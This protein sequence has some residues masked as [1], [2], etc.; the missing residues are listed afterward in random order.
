LNKVFTLPGLKVAMLMIVATSIVVVLAVRHIKADVEKHTADTLKQ[1]LSVTQDS[2]ERWK[3]KLC[4]DIRP[5]SQSAEVLTLVQSLLQT[6]H[7][8]QALVN[9]PNQKRLRSLLGFYVNQHDYVGFFVISPDFISVSSMRDSNLGRI[10]LLRKRGEFLD[11]IFAGQ[12]LISLPQIS[13]VV[14]PDAYGR[15]VDG[16]PTMFVAAPV[17]NASGKVIAALAFRI[18][19]DGDYAHI[20]AMG[21]VGRSMETYV[22]DAHGRMLTSSRFDYQ[23]RKAGLLGP[24]QE[25]ALNIVLRDPGVNLIEEP[26]LLK[27]YMKRPLTYMAAAAVQ[28]KSGINLKG[29]NDY[30]GV[31]VV[32]AWQWNAREGYGLAV[33]MDVEDAYGQ[34]NV[35]RGMFFGVL[36]VLMFMFILMVFLIERLNMQAGRAMMV[37][38]ARYRQLF[39]LI[40]DA[41]AVH[42]QGKV[43]YCNAA[44]VK[45]FGAVGNDDLNGSSIL[46]LVH[47][48]DRAGVEERLRIAMHSDGIVPLN[49]ERLLRL[50]GEIFVAEVEGC[51]FKD[52]DGDA[53]LVVARDISRRKH[54]EEERERL[55][56]A[57]EQS[58]EGILITDAAGKILYANPVIA[59]MLGHSLEDLPG[60]LAA[61][62]C[63]GSQGDILYQKIATALNAGNIWQGDVTLHL[64]DGTQ[65][66]VE[67]RVSPVIQ[68]GETLY[69]VSMDRDI[70]D[71][72]RQQDK[73]GHAQRLESLGVLAGGIAHDFNNILATIMGNASLA[74]MKF[75]GQKDLGNYLCR[76]ED[77]SQRA[78]ALCKQMLAYS[79]KGH[80]I[81]RPVNISL[82]LQEIPKLLQVSISKKVELRLELAADIPTVQADITQLQQVMMNLVI[83]AS[84]A[85]GEDTGMVTLRTGVV[86]AEAYE[87]AQSCTGDD[88]E[89]GRYVLFEVQDSGCGMS[90]ET[91]KKLFDP[92][93]TTK[94]TGR[95]LG[96][97]AVLGI[98]RGHHGAIT[99]KSKEGEGTTFRV[100]LPPSEDAPHADIKSEDESIEWC[101][102]GTVLVVDDEISVRE[103]AVSM[104]EEVGFKTLEACD[105]EEAVDIYRRQCDEIS[106][107]LLD[108]TMPK[109]DG[110]ECFRQ[111][112]DINADVRVI[113]S[114][115]YNE[116]DATQSFAEDDLAGFVQ[117]PYRMETLIAHLRQVLEGQAAV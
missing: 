42:R 38:E 24:Q 98:V 1:T 27:N 111:L 4:Q 73:M 85:I 21:R 26:H 61:E 50:D 51:R 60:M 40:P 89:P 90:R 3:K 23:L 2:L 62:A 86:Q 112:R 84:D 30:R 48:D 31:P 22:F 114:S 16:L 106:L 6:P 107:V 104:L 75:P 58:P 83:N 88:L 69:H 71:E 78:A 56:V 9:N 95:G 116:K 43:A 72:R 93:Y 44:A 17:R 110:V 117:K 63:G 77:A 108:V 11:R 32:G 7:T 37:S 68:D 82:M 33:E 5:W 19:S 36:V 54:A 29:Y 39:E 35:V 25:S 101:P 70:T 99:V 91:L 65:R 28:G 55:R 66:I 105:G 103:A 53:V 80:F 74:K 96:M 100:L 115:G 8:Q 15:L 20:V 109:L 94:F 102:T 79:G 67:R 41:V 76:I 47:P 57:V 81:I 18:R 113:L 46:S 10:N 13:D 34:L 92:F 64:P 59:L 14:L 52:A 87:L 45:M 97:S 12:T 49:E